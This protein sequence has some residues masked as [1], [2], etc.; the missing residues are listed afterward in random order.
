MDVPDIAVEMM[1]D[2]LTI[3]DQ[4][5]DSIRAKTHVVD[6]GIN[7]ESFTIRQPDGG[8]LHASG[9]YDWQ[10]RTFRIDA[11]GQN[12][13]WRGS[14]ARLG[15]AEVR[16]A[17]KFAGD[18]PIDRPAGEGALD[19]AVTGGV[20]GQLVDRGVLSVRLNGDT[21][22]LTGHIPS[23]GALLTGSVNPR[24]P[25]NYDAVLVMNRIDLAP[26]VSFAGLRQGFVSGTASLSANVAGLLT[27]VRHS[28]AFVNLQDVN[29]DV[30]GVPLRLG[31]PARLGWDG[32]ALTIDNLDL[33]VGQGRL[34]AS[35][36]LGQGGLS[37]AR[38][39]SSFKGELGDLVKIGRPFGVP[40]ELE[41]FGSI[42][43]EWQSSG[44][45]EQS[46][47]TLTLQGGSLAWGAL[48]ALRDLKL[49]ATFD[50]ASLNVTQLT[51][52]WQDGGIEATASIP[53][54]VHRGQ[55]GAGR[56]AAGAA[57][58]CEAARQWFDRSSARAVAE[59]G[60]RRRHRRSSVR[61]PRRSHHWRVA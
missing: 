39:Q 10:A 51:G 8:E 27:D 49:D 12:L 22:L 54:E 7:I 1:G 23:L 17:L 45:I 16:V 24:S 53:R 36:R 56:D 55:R 14:L 43:L 46:K 31:T 40:V 19:F 58:V 20:A 5:I 13:V 2:R 3:T 33:G 29:A 6:G 18:G 11:D 52:Q 25:Y 32:N 41:G 21:A 60:D 15:D 50:G 47:A 38:W 26:L 48:P 34:L 42:T 59:P 61:D 4:P 57:W 35:G 37:G 9:R 28:N 30:A 44:G